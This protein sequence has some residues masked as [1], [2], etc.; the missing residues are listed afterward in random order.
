MRI[1]TIQSIDDQLWLTNDKEE[2]PEKD[3]MNDVHGNRLDVKPYGGIWTSTY[4]PDEE[5]DSDWIRWCSYEDYWVGKHG[6]LLQVKDPV[7]IIHI[8]SCDDL[9][10]V[11]RDYSK[12]NQAGYEQIDFESMSDDGYDGI[13]LTKR[14]EAE[15]RLSEPNLYGWDSECTL[16]FN[17]KFTD[18]KYH[19]NYDS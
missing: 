18:V 16:W 5:Y 2:P 6:Y 19:K 10:Q 9:A 4:T 14:G 11:T 7:N 13:H 15:T 8:N 17:W 3:K 1:R 12:Y